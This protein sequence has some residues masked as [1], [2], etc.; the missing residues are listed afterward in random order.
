MSIQYRKVGA[1]GLRRKVWQDGNVSYTGKVMIDT[2]ELPATATGKIDLY[3][4]VAKSEKRSEDSPDLWCTIKVK[5]EVAM[6]PPS[7]QAPLPS[8]DDDS[9]SF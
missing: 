1:S 3:I 7:Q 4:N 6:S 2:Q 9:I 8:N 5:G